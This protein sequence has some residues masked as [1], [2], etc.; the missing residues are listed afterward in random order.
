MKKIVCED[1]GA[2][3]GIWGSIEREADAPDNR[4][5]VVIKCADFSADPPKVIYD[6]QAHTESVSELPHQH[7]KNLIDALYDRS[8]NASENKASTLGSSTAD[9]REAYATMVKEYWQKNPNLVVGGDFESGEDGVPKGW[10]K[11]A[12]QLREPL[13]NLVQWMPEP[14]SSTN[15]VIHF[16]LDQTTAENEGVMY[17]S[18]FFPVEEGAKYRFQCRWRSDAPTVKVFIKCYDEIVPPSKSEVKTKGQGRAAEKSAAERSQASKSQTAKQE[19]R[20]E[21]YRSQQNLK[22]E[23]NTW[24][25]HTEDFTPKHPQYS[26]RWGRVMLYA[27]L[28]PGT[29]D[30]DDVVVKQITDAPSP[31]EQRK[32]PRHSSETKVTI[33]EMENNERRSNKQRTNEHPTNEH[34]SQ[35]RERK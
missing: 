6:I 31:G 27:C 20:R 35:D 5:N 25:T 29:V 9:S 10:E 4:Y 34:P 26:P 18:E 11:T 19:N 17:Y 32:V 8:P 22:G 7:I 21:V 12:G 33:E 1:F 28:K 13:G 16:T 3:I 14:G 2:Q 15:K 24:H 23:L 30:F